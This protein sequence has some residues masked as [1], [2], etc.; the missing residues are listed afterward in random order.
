M[1]LGGSNT[2]SKHMVYETIDKAKKRLQYMFP[3]DRKHVTVKQIYSI[4]QQKKCD[5]LEENGRLL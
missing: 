3:E 1:T 4:E 2:K 5:D